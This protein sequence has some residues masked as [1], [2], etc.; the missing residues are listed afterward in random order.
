MTNLTLKLLFAFLLIWGL[1][2]GGFA[3]VT[4]V[5]DAGHGGKDPGKE[6][7]VRFKDEKDLNLALAL[8]VGQR[9]KSELPNTKIYYTRTSDSFLSLEE[10]VRYAN[11]LK[12]D[13]FISIHCNSNP[14]PTVKGAKTHIHSKKNKDAY[15]LAT[16]VQQEL[17]STAKRVN[18][19]VQDT[20]ER[21]ENLYVLQYTNMPSLLIE[22]GFLTNPSEEKY[23]NSA[24]GQELI[25]KS[26]S[27]GLTRFLLYKHPG[28]SPSP[29]YKVQIL[30]T[31]KP[32]NLD[33]PQFKQ[34]GMHIEELKVKKN[35]QT[36]YKYLVG[37]EKTNFRAKL[38]QQKVKRK[39]FDD[40]FI[41]QMR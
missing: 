40:A 6:G 12:A 24:F 18:R 41:V 7:S 32:V 26:I 5:I 36:L 10:R 15:L 23:I 22:C 17:E 39:G 16:I 20:R 9:I 21:G 38:I 27:R 31:S 11:R 35:N 37:T 19:G 28:L 2:L 1:P 8:K 34:L 3:Q 25:A 33:S 14:A 30:A 29:T 4:V 13:Y